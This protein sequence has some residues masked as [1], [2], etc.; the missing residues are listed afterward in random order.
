MQNVSIVVDGIHC[1]INQ[2]DLTSCFSIV[3][4]IQPIQIFRYPPDSQVL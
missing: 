3:H 1:A 2:L 4:L